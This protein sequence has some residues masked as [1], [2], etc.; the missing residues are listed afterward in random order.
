VCAFISTLDG[1]GG[2]HTLVS[3]EKGHSVNEFLR[4]SRV[5]IPRGYQILFA[6]TLR[7]GQAGEI[8]H[9]QIINF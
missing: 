9:F 3:E 7:I 1:V 8:S 6:I 2:L 5:A 4:P